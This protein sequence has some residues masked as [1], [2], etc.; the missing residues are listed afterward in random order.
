MKNITYFEFTPKIGRFW[1]R[2]K[3]Y[4]AKSEVEKSVL[5]CLIYVNSNHKSFEDIAQPGFILTLGWWDFAISFGIVVRTWI[6]GTCMDRQA[7]KNVKHGNVQFIIFNKFDQAYI[8]GV[9]HKENK[10]VNFDKTWWPQFR[11]DDKND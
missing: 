5:L 11:S 3:C 1:I 8:D 6:Y 10:W 9:G 2:L 4:R 7:R